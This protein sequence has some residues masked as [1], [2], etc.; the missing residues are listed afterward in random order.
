M[1]A[2]IGADAARLC[3][4]R[5]PDDVLAE[6][7]HLAALLPDPAD[8]RRYET[9]FRA[10]EAFWARIVDG[11]G[12]LTY[13]LAFNSLVGARDAGGIALSIYA[14][15]VD[16]A[17]SAAIPLAEAIAARDGARAAALGRE[18]LERALPD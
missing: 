7:P 6:L 1:R 9:R 14:A 18:L 12:N 3:A 13:R 5:G 11:S 17:R 16:D 15:E 8:V 4:L 10:Y 2:S